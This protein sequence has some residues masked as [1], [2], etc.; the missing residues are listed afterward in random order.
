MAPDK[1]KYAAD[2]WKRGSEAIAKQ[3][4]DYAIECFSS[5]VEFAPDNLTYRQCLR[6]AVRKK[7][8]D[9]KTGAK[10][11]S[12]K[13]MG[14]R[15]KIKKSR[16]Q[17][18][19][20]NIIKLAEEGLKVNP[21]DAALNAAVAESCLELEY[22]GEIAVFCYQCALETDP[23]NIEYI[24]CLARL[25]EDRGEF[26]AAIKHWEKVRKMEPE[27]TEARSK[28]TQIGARSIMRK[29][30]FEDAETSREVQKDQTAYD[31]DRSKRVQKGPAVEG[32]GDSPEADLE[33]AIR[34][35]PAEVGNYIK[36]A[37][38]YRVEKRLDD[39]AA[40]FKKAVEVSGGDQSVREKLEDVE[41]DQLRH[42]LESAKERAAANPDDK[43]AAKIRAALMKELVLREV[44]VL[45]ARV[46]RYPRDVKFKF[47]LA[48]RYRQLQETQKAIPLLQQAAGDSRYEVNAL[49][50]LAKCFISVKKNSLA[51]RQLTRL[52][53]KINALDHKDQFLTAKYWVARICEDAGDKEEAVEHYTDVIGVEYD[54]KDACSRL[55]KLE[56]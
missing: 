3:N 39:A 14:T 42:N 43:E 29:G 25:L 17:K 9:N 4:W 50:D 1:K 37:E 51:R 24:R 35:D 16:M 40:M 7:Y 19:W 11:A 30:G 53:E 56:S 10:M 6:G 27:D 36:L 48:Q 12:V 46:E 55:D 15:G 34:K 45:S 49:L 54:Y 5:S 8:K 41:L 23:D 28:V 2:F 31:A 22:G 18:D 33:R 32:P 13:L 20:E 44:E 21:W 52:L 47:E 26:D 38:L